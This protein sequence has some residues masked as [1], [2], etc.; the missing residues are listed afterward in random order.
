MLLIAWPKNI[1]QRWSEIPKS[2]GK[3]YLVLLSAYFIV[4][5]ILLS[6]RTVPFTGYETDGVFYMIQADTLFTD[7]FVPPTYGGGI[8]M[9]VSIHF[10]KYCV[11]DTFLA[12]K[13]VSAVAGFLYLAASLGIM[14]RLC[15]PLTGFWGTLLLLVNPTVLI[16]STTSL[17]DMLAASLVLNAVWVLLDARNAQRFFIAG[18][19]LG[20]GWT[21]R[22]VNVVFFPLIVVALLEKG[23]GK[24]DIFKKIIAGSAGIL[25]GI[26]PQMIVNSIY[27]G[28]P[29]HT[30]NWQ[31]IAMML[32]GPGF[33]ERVHS[34]GEILRN[35]WLRLCIVWTKQFVVQTPIKLY[36]TAYL[37]VLLVV[38]GFIISLRLSEKKP[39]LALWG[40]CVM[41]YLFFVSSVWRI[42]LRYFLPVLPLVMI[43]GVVMW[44]KMLGESRYGFVIGIVLMA[45]MSAFASIEN[46]K[47]LVNKQAP[48]FRQAGLFLKEQAGTED[49]ILASQ[50]HIFFYA[51]RPGIL[52]ENLNPGEI[53]DLGKTISDKNVK[54]I[55]FDERNGEIKFKAL[56][57][58]FNPVSPFDWRLAFSNNNSPRIFIWHKS[59]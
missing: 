29:V 16:Y 32:Y 26:L 53:G 30:D 40:C 20:L 6:Y 38:P 8:G 9:P 23:Q 5:L 27:F 31:N 21:A 11:D 35:D 52:F 22:S 51:R 7:K 55:V 28:N 54:W 42:E 10:V 33:S 43:S 56:S 25:L 58:L 57:N 19:F 2:G 47:E 39:L 44:Q 36:E 3:L 48:E 37:P 12:A 34:F 24:S 45:C 41:L 14:T 13:I 18:I 17:S 4:V 46:I 15:T 49:L 50:P 1:L 59:K